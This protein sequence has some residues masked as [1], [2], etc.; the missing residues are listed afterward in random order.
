MNNY[1]EEKTQ[2]SVKILAHKSLN[3]SSD[4]KSQHAIH[5]FVKCKSIIA[6]TVLINCRDNP[7]KTTRL[8]L[9]FTFIVFVGKRKNVCKSRH[10]CN[11]SHTIPIFAIFLPAVFRIT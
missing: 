6:T 4:I 5:T 11:E 9:K 3:P 7:Q 1:Q 8:R 10:D 2:K